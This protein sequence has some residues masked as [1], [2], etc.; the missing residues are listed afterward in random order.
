VDAPHLRKLRKYCLIGIFHG[1]M[2]LTKR[3]HFFIF[4]LPKTIAH[5]PIA[6]G[7]SFRSL[8]GAFMF[9]KLPNEKGDL[10]QVC[11]EFSPPTSELV[12]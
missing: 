9:A 2:V 10:I 8:D 5:L 11:S 1:A 4:K 3:L 12:A 7:L 6:E